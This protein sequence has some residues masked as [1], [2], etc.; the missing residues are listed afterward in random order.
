MLLLN[1]FLILHSRL[2]YERG[3]VML[4]SWQHYQTLHVHPTLNRISRLFE[5]MECQAVE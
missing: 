2:G 5:G 3:L 1:L 4:L